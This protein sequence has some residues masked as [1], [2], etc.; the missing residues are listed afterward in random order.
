MIFNLTNIFIL[1][2][3]ILLFLFIIYKNCKYYIVN[4]KKYFHEN[5]D[6]IF[7]DK[8]NN[9]DLYKKRIKDK[10]T[11]SLINNIEKIVNSKLYFSGSILRNDFIEYNSDIDMFYFSNNIEDDFKKIKKYLS[12]IKKLYKFKGSFSFSKYNTYRIY[13]EEN[14]Y[15]NIFTF[16]YENIKLQFTIYKT[17]YKNIILRF[18]LSFAYSIL[19]YQLYLLYLLKKCKNKIINKNL[20]KKIKKK[21]FLINND[22]D[23]K[24]IVD[25]NYIQIKI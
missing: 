15:G 17:I 7:L 24:Y 18:Y 4:K 5:F 11:L 21:L 9:I 25:Q 6:K 2:I 23:Y 1:I 14:I 19:D 16:K 22:R 3:I 20:Y 8:Y 12:F 10:F 13:L